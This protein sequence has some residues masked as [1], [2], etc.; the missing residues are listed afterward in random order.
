MNDSLAIGRPGKSDGVERVALGG[1]AEVLGRVVGRVSVVEGT[2]G[3]FGWPF[4]VSAPRTGA[5][6]GVAVDVQPRTNVEQDFLHFVGNGPVGA[7]ADIHQQVAV[8]ADDVD[9]L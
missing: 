9:Q 2:A 3:D 5:I 1:E 4:A 8:L 6:D 7:R